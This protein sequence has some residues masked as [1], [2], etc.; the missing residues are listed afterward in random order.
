MTS[1]DALHQLDE[2][3]GLALAAV[4]CREG[5]AGRREGSAELGV[6]AQAP[7]GARQRLGVP[8]RDGKRGASDAGQAAR[9]PVGRQDHGPLH[10]AAV[11]QLGGDERSERRR[12]GERDEQ[13]V[14]RTQ[15]ARRQRL[16][17]GVTEHHGAGR[18]AGREALEALALRAAAQHDELEAGAEAGRGVHGA[19]EALRQSHVAGVGPDEAVAREVVPRPPASCR[20]PADCFP[21]SARP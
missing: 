5:G 9:L 8:R 16:G 20:G 12:V 4:L 18:K 3:A 21:T 1:R 17:H 7:H 15:V 6:V 14:G 10:R 2:P 11:E 19:V 13:G